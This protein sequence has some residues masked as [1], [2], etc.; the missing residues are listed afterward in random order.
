MN[1]T[2]HMTVGALSAGLLLA[3]SLSNGPQLSFELAGYQVY[4][5]IAVFAGAMGG[6]APDVDMAKS[7]ARRF[8][9]RVV[10]TCLILSALS[11]AIMYF[12]PPYGYEFWDGT[13]RLGAG[14]DRGVSLVLAAF[15]IF[16]IVIAEKA[17]HR[18]FTH[19]VVGLAVVAAPLVFMLITGVMFVG[20]YIA[21]SAQIGFLLGWLSHM[22]IDSFNYP[23]TPWLWPLVKKHFRL[24]R[25]ASGKEGEATFLLVCIVIFAACY[26]IIII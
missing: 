17:K 16:I 15:C 13:V 10:R 7:R 8:L 11:L 6:L 19:T 1:S 3:H 5:L 26:A 9:R 4:P 23:G 18:G 21:V 25:I 12:I 24:M 14:A 22:V 20:A 2:T